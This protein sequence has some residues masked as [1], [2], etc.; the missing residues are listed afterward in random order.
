MT[1]MMDDDDDN[2]NNNNNNN[3]NSTDCVAI[4]YELYGLGFESQW[5]RDFPKDG[6]TYLKT[7]TLNG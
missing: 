4:R 6:V 5:R 3:Q 7:V 1:T 2:N